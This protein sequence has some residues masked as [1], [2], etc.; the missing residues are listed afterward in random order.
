M[1]APG[2]PWVK[3]GRPS[4]ADSLLIH[5]AA[6][7]EAEIHDRCGHPFDVCGNDENEGRFHV[8]PIRCYA[9]AATEEY[10]ERHK[11]AIKDASWGFTTRLLDEGE[12]V[13]DPLTFDP[14][15]A[16][17]AWLAQREKYGLA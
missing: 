14:V 6:I 7:Y 9:T 8:E 4:R 5:A 1:V 11:D 15:K 17:A 12:T 2:L 10:A 16:R 3:P 13:A